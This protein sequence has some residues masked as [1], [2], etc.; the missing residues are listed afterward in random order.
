M[1]PVFVHDPRGGIDLHARFSLDGNRDVE[2]DWTEY[3]IEYVENGAKK[4][5]KMPFT[6]ADFAASETRFKKQFRKITNDANA[7]P[8]HEYIELDA[9][10]REGKY[11][12][13]YSTDDDKKLIKLE[14]AKTLL[15]LVQDRRKYWRTLQYLAGLDV[16]LVDCG[17][18]E[19]AR[20]H[21]EPVHRSAQ[22]S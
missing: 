14:V 11:P 12:F 13:V 10:A 8:V 21:Q 15:Q 19:G 16:A 1:N 22:R 20:S 17:A 7:V 6:P 2:K 4:L 9:S 3:T 5:M 18:Q